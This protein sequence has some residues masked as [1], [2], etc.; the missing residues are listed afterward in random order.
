MRHRIT[1]WGSGLLLGASLALAGTAQAEDATRSRT[2]ESGTVVT[3]T[4]TGTSWTR[5]RT[6]VNGHGGT[7]TMTGSG[8]TTANPDGTTNLEAQK[9]YTG[10]QGRALEVEKSGTATPIENGRSYEGTRTYTNPQTGNAK[11]LDVDASRTKTVNDDG[12]TSYERTKTVTNPETG[13]TLTRDHDTTVTHTGDGVAVDRTDTAVGP[14]GGT[15]TRHTTGAG[16]QAEDGSRSWSSTTQGD[17]NGP[18]GRERSWTTE[19]LGASAPNDDGGRDRESSAT[20]TG[21]KGR[22]WNRDSSGS[23]WRD[24]NGARGGSRESTFSGPRAKTANTAARRRA[25]RK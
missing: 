12:S 15:R 6:T 24:G 21:T 5:E 20:R 7:S 3:P 14:N 4:E 11:T 17:A 1:G 22:T 18:K 13:K 23:T 2:T 10:P 19:R 9:T 25:G 8:A 16:T